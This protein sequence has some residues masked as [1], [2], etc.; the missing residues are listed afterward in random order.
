MQHDSS[1][2]KQLEGSW[3]EHARASGVAHEGIAG[4][5]LLEHDAAAE[6]QRAVAQRI[7]IL[8]QTAVGDYQAGDAEGECENGAL[9]KLFHFCPGFN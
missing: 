9:H 8:R 4:W 7:G 5:N 6:H 2:E 3:L 1:E